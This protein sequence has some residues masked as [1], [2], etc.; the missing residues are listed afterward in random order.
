MSATPYIL[1]TS[2]RLLRA[3]Q[4][5]VDA[6]RAFWEPQ[7]QAVLKLARRYGYEREHSHQVMRLA[8][9]LF[10][11]LWPLHRLSPQERFWLQCAAVLHDIGRYKEREHH[12]VALRI[13]LRSPLLP[14][15]K[16][17]RRVIGSIARYHTKAAPNKKHEHY[18]ALSERKRLIV[19]QLAAILRLADA[20][21]RGHS[22]RVKRLWCDISKDCIVLRCV[23]REGS[24]TGPLRE[25]ARE[26][27]RLLVKVFKR[28]LILRTATIAALRREGL[29]QLSDSGMLKFV[30]A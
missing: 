13:V 29:L 7:F 19:R 5:D 23:T 2:Q 17:M 28:K 3:Q 26:K 11:Q 20:L 4:R 27:G 9:R 6:A 21:D 25:R 10:D 14:F 22:K 18:S 12:K 24:K 16:K 1:P 15:D 8:L 30:V